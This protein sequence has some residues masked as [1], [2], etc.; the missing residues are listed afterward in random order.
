MSAL[1][2][3]TLNIVLLLLVGCASIPP[4]EP[5]VFNKKLAT[6]ENTLAVSISEVPEVK[7]SYPGATCLLCL[8]VASVANGGLSG[9]VK[10]LNADDLQ[11]LGS[12][13]IESLKGSG[14]TVKVLENTFSLK[15]LKKYKSVE[16]NEARKDYRP[17]KE[18]LQASHLLVLD[19]DY[20]GVKR[21][22]ASY[23]PTSEPYA[24]VEGLAY[25]VNLTTNV[26]EWYL[27]IYQRHSPGQEWKQPPSYPTVINAYYQAVETTKEEI[28]SALNASEIVE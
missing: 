9:E 7:I 16:L 11:P 21:D 6:A 4:Q 25:L 15:K 17:L 22:Y 2:V 8:G 10:K 26:Y 13:L 20:V 14:H 18:E 27:P 19:L 12:Q 24:I 28:L 1:R 5:V 23:V 3:L